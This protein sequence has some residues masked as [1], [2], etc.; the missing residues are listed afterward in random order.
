M[1]RAVRKEEVD[2][3]IVE[4]VLSFSTFLEGRLVHELRSEEISLTDSKRKTVV[5]M[6]LVPHGITSVKFGGIFAYVP[7]TVRRDQRK[8]ILFRHC[9]EFV[10]G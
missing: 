10:R 6:A 8:G 7:I 9:R 5:P 1:Q 4:L 2:D 3:S